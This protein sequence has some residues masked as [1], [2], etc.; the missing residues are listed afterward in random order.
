MDISSSGLPLFAC[1]VKTAGEGSTVQLTGYTHSPATQG[2]AHWLDD[3][4]CLDIYIHLCVTL[5]IP[6][7]D[8]L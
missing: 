2:N 1:T 3:H 6:V 5:C 8:C 7:V 4:A